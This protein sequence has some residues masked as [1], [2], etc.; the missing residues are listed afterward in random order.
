MASTTLPWAPAR[1]YQNVILTAPGGTTTVGAGAAVVAAGAAAVAAE[2]VAAGLV[3][4]GACVAAGGALAAPQAAS[5]RVSA[6]KALVSFFIME[7]LLA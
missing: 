2:A 7:I 4:T 1:A 5:N 3:A 6:P